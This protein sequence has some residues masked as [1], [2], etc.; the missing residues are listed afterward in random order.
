VA[1]RAQL[2]TYS[3]L[4]G[5]RRVPSEYEIVTSRLLYHPERGLEV[6]VPFATWFARHGAAAAFAGVDWERFADP[7][8]TTYASYTALQAEQERF[9]AQL[10]ARMEEGDGELPPAAVR[11]CD[12]AAA[13]LRFALHG[14][15]MVAAYLGQLAP[16][17]RITTVLALQAAD[18]MRRLQ[19]LAYRMALH[20]QRRP[21]WRDD[22]RR[23]WQSASAWQPLRR[24]TEELLVTWDFGEALVA[25]VTALKPALDRQLWPV[26]A[27]RMRA[28]GDYLFGEVLLASQGDAAWSAQ[29]SDALL[30]L[31]AAAHPNHGAVID[32]ARQ[33]WRGRSDDAIATLVQEQP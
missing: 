26:L 17:G 10:F 1:P 33:R 21:E 12:Q 32:Q 16:A 18:E 27:T 4:A 29:W 9:V 24:L 6:N 15:Q 3:H 31:I 5:E 23:I 2:R 25:L 30:T 19:H 22:S 28:A 20:R 13:P 14:L 7:R 8:Q 11:L